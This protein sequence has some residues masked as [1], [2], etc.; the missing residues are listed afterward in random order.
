MEH[1]FLFPVISLTQT[2]SFTYDEGLRVLGDHPDGVCG[3]CV[4]VQNYC[5]KTSAV[6]IPGNE[7]R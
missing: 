5:T 4:W 7:A 2:Q 6:Q 1:I 3:I